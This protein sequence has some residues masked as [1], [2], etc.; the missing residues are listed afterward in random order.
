MNE[1]DEAGIDL[2]MANNNGGESKKFQLTID[3]VDEV[4]SDAN[5]V[6]EP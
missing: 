2:D 1:I 5:T 6:T 4:L 3:K